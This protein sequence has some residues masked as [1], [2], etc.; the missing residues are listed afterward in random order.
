MQIIIVRTRNIAQRLVKQ[1]IANYDSANY[2]HW[3]NVGP[4]NDIQRMWAVNDSADC[5]QWP[6]VGPTDASQRIQAAYDSADNIHWPNVGPTDVANVFYTNLIAWIIY[7]GPTLVQRYK[8][9]P[10]QNP[11]VR[12]IAY[13]G[14]T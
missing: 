1:M 14:P 5:T 6:N 2:T 4:T 10:N 7:V 8:T 9:N 12:P 11:T 13:V 3:P